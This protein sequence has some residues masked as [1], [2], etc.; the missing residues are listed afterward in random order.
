[1][2]DLNLSMNGISQ[3]SAELLGAALETNTCLRTLDVSNNRIELIGCSAIAQ[4]LSQ[5]ETLTT[6]KVMDH[7]MLLLQ[8]MS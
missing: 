7:A 2:D 8:V 4:G 5:N 1:M 3:A 6:L